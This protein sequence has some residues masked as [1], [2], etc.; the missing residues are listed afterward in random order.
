MCGAVR[1]TKAGTG[2]LAVHHAAGQ[3]LPNEKNV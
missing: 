2:V 1:N 3:Q